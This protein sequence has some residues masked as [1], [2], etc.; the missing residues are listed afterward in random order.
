MLLHFY[1]TCLLF[2]FFSLGIALI[3]KTQELVMRSLTLLMILHIT[4][5]AIGQGTLGFTIFISVLF[6]L[7]LYEVSKHY[8]TN[9]LWLALVSIPLFVIGFYSNQQFV[10]LAA[11]W[12]IPISVL[13]FT[14]AKET[15]QSPS[16]LFGFSLCFLLPCS[17]FLVKILSINGGAILSILLLLQFNDAF[18][19]LFGKQFGKTHLFPTISPN[20]T[21]EG[22]LFGSVGIIIGIILLHT[23][24][25]VL[26]SDAFS[27]DIILFLLI[28]ILGNLGDLMLSALKRKLEIKDFSNILPGHGGILDRFDNI[29]FIAPIFYVLLNHNLI[30]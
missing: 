2:I 28:L 27:K 14:G 13:T 6:I 18:G 4:C 1:L 12:L 16:Y 15:I 9:H 20:K 26:S 24:I 19:Y 21:L 7:S 17:I 22:Y 29:L 23:Y 3:K 11:L 10:E 5:L 8:Q 25:P 30:L